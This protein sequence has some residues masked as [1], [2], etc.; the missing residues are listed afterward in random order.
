MYFFTIFP[1]FTSG[2]ENKHQSSWE[3]KQKKLWGKSYTD[4]TII[5]WR[6]G[7]LWRS[8]SSHFYESLSRWGVQPMEACGWPL[9]PSAVQD[10]WKHLSAPSGQAQ[11]W[12]T[13]VCFC[14]SAGGAGEGAARG[15]TDGRTRWTV[16]GARTRTRTHR[17][18]QFCRGRSKPLRDPM[19]FC[20]AIPSW[21]C[22]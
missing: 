16:V 17:L 21:P 2:K 10:K 1:K 3:L 13:R 11:A 22:L 19:V 8:K 14:V 6:A 18:K 20:G 9:H 4:K 12:S 5:N 7:L 15:G